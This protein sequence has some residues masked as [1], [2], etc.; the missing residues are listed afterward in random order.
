MRFDDNG[1]GDPNYEPNTTGG[2]VADPTYAEPPLKISGDAARYEQ[3]RGADDDYVQ[4][5][6][7]FRLMSPAQ[8]E[9][10]MENIAGSLGKV[11]GDLQE[12]MIAH[13]RKADKAYGDGVA[14]KLG[15]L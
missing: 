8:Q 3:A 14:R 15:L 9:E 11:P 5:G 6:H 10:L 12:R 4:P 1:G 2:P 7:L 13:F